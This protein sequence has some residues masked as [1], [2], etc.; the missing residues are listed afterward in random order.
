MINTAET[1][2]LG[3]EL[4]VQYLRRNGFLIAERNW[5]NGSHE[6]DIIA[7]RRGTVHFVEVKTRSATGL[8][9]PESAFNAAKR[10]A[11]LRAAAV[12]MARAGSGCEF[13]FD[14]AAVELAPD[15]THEIRYFESVIESNW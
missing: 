12:Y 10:R 5:R 14:L 2:R 8:T 9:S 15:H 7:L 6:I 1:G 13:Q 4:V 3:E 11:L